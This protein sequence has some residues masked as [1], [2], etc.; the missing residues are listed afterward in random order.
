VRTGYLGHPQYEF[1]LAP[2]NIARTQ[3]WYQLLGK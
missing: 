2:A 1:E 3:H